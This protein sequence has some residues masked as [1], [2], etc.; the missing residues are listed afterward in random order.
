MIKA[1][2]GN[3]MGSFSLLV[4]LY[5]SFSPDK[6]SL[7]RALLAGEMLIRGSF[8]DAE[9]YRKL[10]QLADSEKMLYDKQ[11]AQTVTLKRFVLTGRLNT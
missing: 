1:K 3:S 2:S 9:L 11:R 4:L 7:I 8:F 10:V 5:F 6:Y